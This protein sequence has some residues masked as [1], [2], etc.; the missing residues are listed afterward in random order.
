[1]AFEISI[2]VG[3]QFL[4]IFLKKKQ[5]Q[6]L[7]RVLTNKKIKKKFNLLKYS[8]YQKIISENILS[9]NKTSLNLHRIT[10]SKLNKH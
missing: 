3:T 10:H 9:T 7:Q 2:L 4:R 6:I 8:A 5:G 1:M